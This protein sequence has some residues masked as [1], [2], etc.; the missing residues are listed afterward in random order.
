M[1]SYLVHPRSY[2]V[3]MRKAWDE[4]G[5]STGE[6]DR[7]WMSMAAHP[8]NRPRGEAALSRDEF[9]EARAVAAD[10]IYDVTKAMLEPGA[11]IADIVSILV[12]PFWKT[13]VEFQGVA[14]PFGLEELGL[15]RHPLGRWRRFRRRLPTR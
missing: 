4:A 2:E 9:N 5:L 3:T 15:P 10:D 14:N 12:P 6:I 7:L 13:F 1:D 8:E 11:D